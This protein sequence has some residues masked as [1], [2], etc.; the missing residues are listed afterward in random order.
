MSDK[1]AAADI[2]AKVK[3]LL[4]S[5]TW[6]EHT[7]KETQR[8]YFFCKATKQTTWDLRKVAAALLAAEA[9]SLEDCN[10]KKSVQSASPSL[11]PRTATAPHQHPQELSTSQVRTHAAVRKKTLLVLPPRFETETR[12]LLLQSPQVLPPNV[13]MD[14]PKE[15]HVAVALTPHRRPQ[16]STVTFSIPTGQ[17]EICSDTGE[18]LLGM[19]KY[20][21]QLDS[22]TGVVC[23]LSAIKPLLPHVAFRIVSAGCAVLPDCV[24]LLAEG[25]RAETALSA[26]ISD[27]N[28]GSERSLVQRLSVWIAEAT[29][30][31]AKPHHPVPAAVGEG[32][33]AQHRA[34]GCSSSALT[35]LLND[36]MRGSSETSPSSA[37]ES[38]R[39]E[40][41]E[42]GRLL[43]LRASGFHRSWERHADPARLREVYAKALAVPLGGRT[44]PRGGCRLLGRAPD[45]SGI[46]AELED[47]ERQLDIEISALQRRR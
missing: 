11:S 22:A 2:D 18:V 45:L 12:S 42:A 9:S 23:C 10:T 43:C 34:P 1:S 3:A 19:G 8:V 21:L 17:L 39:G 46:V 41:K 27:C 29:T 24:E 7:D 30:V 5:G 13:S 6:K 37:C 26:T 32:A 28:A 44:A 16:W 40:G 20:T 31:D 33:R 25:G 36:A 4:A 14:A 47:A 15:L 35:T 38:R